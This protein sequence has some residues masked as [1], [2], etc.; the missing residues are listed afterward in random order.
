MASAGSG[1]FGGRSFWSALASAGIEAEVR[2]VQHLR[3]LTCRQQATNMDYTRPQAT[4]YA[5]ALATDNR[6]GFVQL[7]Q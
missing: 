1:G 4:Y 3:Y 2:H 7:L 6:L 5:S